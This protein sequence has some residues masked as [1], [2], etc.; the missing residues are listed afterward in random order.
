MAGEPAAAG[1]APAPGEPGAGDGAGSAPGPGVGELDATTLTDKWGEIANGFES[2]QEEFLRTDVLQ[3]MQT[4]L[5]QHFEAI[6]KHPRE[7]V[8]QK[9]QSVTD[10]SKTEVL[11]DAADA[12]SWQGAMKRL[13]AQEVASRVG[14]RQEDMRDQ[15]QTVHASI[16]LF[17]NNA[18]LIPGTKQF[19]GELATR[20]VAFAKDY[21]VRSGGGKLL[22]WNVP[23]QPLVNQLRTQMAAER[24]AKAPAAPAAPTAQQQRAAEQPR[25]QV[26]TFAAPAAPAPGPQAGIVSKAGTG[27]GTEDNA[28]AGVL[29]AFA[30][31]NGFQI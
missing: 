26:G 13:L 14:A 10:L 15:F 4:E 12:E 11:R 31:Q 19:D 18:D 28:A 23:V 7:L 2:S 30:R 20:F 8:G 25:T 27:A 1:A 6:N 29:A 9:V 17:R 24:A 3:E 5:P 21:E 22:G 16:D